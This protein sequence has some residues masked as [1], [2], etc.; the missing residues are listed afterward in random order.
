M[1]PE[2]DVDPD[3]IHSGAHALVGYD[4]DLRAEDGSAR[5]TLTVAS[6]HLNRN[7]TLHGGIIAMML[8]AAA[9]FAASRA[10]TA[11]DF[12]P[13]LTISLNTNYVAPATE[14]MVIRATGRIT[15]GGASIVH[16]GAELRDMDDNLL[17]TAIG[18]FKRVRRRQE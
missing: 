7:G 17:A 10:G 9:G 13:V 3:S 11:T 2:F 4:V 12:A 6:K 14:G 1:P 16:S 18:V 5:V 8:D 15:G